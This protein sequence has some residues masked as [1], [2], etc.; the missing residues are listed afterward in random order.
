M[1]NWMFFSW[2]LLLSNAIN[3][4]SL[5]TP[6]TASILP[7]ISMSKGVSL[8][9]PN[10]DH[11]YWW[12]HT[13][14]FS[15]QFSEGPAG[16]VA[17]QHWSSQGN[18]IVDMSLSN[19][20]CILDLATDDQG[21]VVLSGVYK[22]SLF[23]NGNLVLTDENT[24]SDNN[25][26]VLYVSS[27]GQEYQAWNLDGFAEYGFSFPVVDFGPDQ[28]IYCAGSDYMTGWIYRWQPDESPALWGS[29]VELKVFGDIEV[30]DQGQVAFASA[31]FQ[32]QV[33]VGDQIFTAPNSYNVLIGILDSNANCIGIQFIPDITIQFA[34]VEWLSNGSILAAGDWYAEGSIGNFDLSGPQWVYSYFLCE[35]D[36]NGNVNWATAH[37]HNPAGITG[38]FALG[39]TESIAADETGGFYLF[40]QQRG[41]V[42]WSPSLSTFGNEADVTNEYTATLTHWTNHTPSNAQTIYGV[43][44]P[45][46]YQVSYRDGLLAVSGSSEYSDTLLCNDFSVFQFNGSIAFLFTSQNFVGIS[47]LMEELAYWTDQFLVFPGIIGEYHIWN[48]M[49]EQIETGFCTEQSL[50]WSEMNLPNGCYLI[51]TE[52]GNLKF[53]KQ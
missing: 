20:V 49:G 18:L 3:G 52:A 6:Y 51:Q 10:A 39:R 30:N 21:N 46:M 2:A 12:V 7:S 8:H 36:T 19:E 47:A 34:E 16:L 32:G 23:V 45:E 13:L 29:G 25:N 41:D 33:S 48:A 24:W 37:P 50:L 27:S 26:F 4:Q 17:V 31:C 9:A 42:Y 28:S 38:D 1:K 53:M 5:N 11:S 40:G 22:D 15:E 43:T 44:L 14:E 35:M